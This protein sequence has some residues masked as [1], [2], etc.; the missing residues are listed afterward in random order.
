MPF[1]VFSLI[2]TIL[3]ARALFVCADLNIAEHLASRPMS[4]AEIA[5][6]TQ[7]D[8]QSLQRLLYFLELHEVFD[9]NEDGAYKLNDFSCRLCAD[10]PQTVKSYILHDDETRWNCF[11]HLG[12]SIE[13]GKAAFDELYGKDYFAYLKNDR[14][15]SGRFNDA[16]TTL[17]KS[18]NERIAQGVSF[19][20]VVAD[21]GG[22]KGHLIDVIAKEKTIDQGILFDLPEVVE[23]VDNLHASCTTVA[24]SFFEKIG[25][26]ADIFILKRILHD[27]DDEQAL[28]ILQQVS[29]AMHTDTR[30]YIC[31][32]ILDYS[33]DKQL[34]AAYDLVLL[35]IFQGR[36]RTK[37]QYEVLLKQAG[38]S[39]VT[40]HHIDDIM[41]VMECKKIQE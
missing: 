23:Q 28:A 35:S 21:I 37:N 12:Y 16:M 8:P 34:L 36:E 1:N 19:H 2:K 18:E 22:G 27:W 29:A 32:G 30:L 10:H 11:G 17:S 14:L 3:L 4:A 13:T 39:I 31:E 38:L 7:Q 41:C 40:I 25:V 24:G 33:K 15:L 20:G 26:N 6:V 5:S 9:R